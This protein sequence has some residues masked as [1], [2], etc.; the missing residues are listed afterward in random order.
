MENQDGLILPSK[1]GLGHCQLIPYEV[2]ISCS[3]MSNI[4]ALT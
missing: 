4:Y 1:V 2:F 3:S